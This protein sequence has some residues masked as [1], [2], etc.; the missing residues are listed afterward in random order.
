MYTYA[1]KGCGRSYKYDIE[2]VTLMAET[3]EL[4]QMFTVLGYTRAK[5][6]IK[7][8]LINAKWWKWPKHACEDPFIPMPIR[9]VGDVQKQGIQPATL[10][11]ERPKFHHRLTIQCYRHA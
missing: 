4:E 2:P 5:N 10:M 1:R 9:V 6:G 11:P 3:P 8:K 7:I